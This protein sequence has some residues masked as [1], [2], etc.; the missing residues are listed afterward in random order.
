MHTYNRNTV[1]IICIVFWSQDQ[2]VTKADQ[3]H[4]SFRYTLD[5]NALVTS[6]GMPM[7]ERDSEAGVV[8]AKWLA[9]CQAR[10]RQLTMPAKYLNYKCKFHF[11]YLLSTEESHCMYSKKVLFA[12]IWISPFCLIALRSVSYMK[13][14]FKAVSFSRVWSPRDQLI[15]NYKRFKYP[16]NHQLVDMGLIYIPT[17]AFVRPHAMGTLVQLID[18]QSISTFQN[19]AKKGRQGQI[20][21]FVNTAIWFQFYRDL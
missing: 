5:A 7:S 8:H 10:I 1:I 15:T 9:P 2:F 3:V 21:Y 17:T 11:I 16:R 14:S 12:F 6:H 18:T 13:Y 4:K 20:D 19:H